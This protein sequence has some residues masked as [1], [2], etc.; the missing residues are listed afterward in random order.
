MVRRRPIAPRESRVLAPLGIGL[1]LE[2][3]LTAAYGRDQRPELFI[4]SSQAR[5]TDPCGSTTR[6]TPAETEVIS[7]IHV[8]LSAASQDEVDA[9]H[10]EGLAAGG[11]DNGLPS[12][13]PEYH[14]TYYGAFVLDA[15]GHNLE[16]VFHGF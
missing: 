13:R 12:L 5:P 2:R 16:A 14:P 15:N 4:R 9:F 11:R 1:V 8:A 7:P 3:E 10:R 6:A